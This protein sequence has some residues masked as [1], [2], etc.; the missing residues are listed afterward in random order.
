M[1]T[2]IELTAALVASHA[3][4]T[5]MTSEQLTQEIQNVYASLKALE[6]GTATVE[7]STPEQPKLTIKQAFKKD[8]VI[9]MVCG[10]GGFKTLKRHLNQLHD[11]KPGAYRKQFNIPSSQPLVAKS[12]SESR[13][14]SANER[15]LGDVLAKAR[16]TRAAGNKKVDASVTKTTKAEALAEKAKIPVPMKVSKA[17]VPTKIEKKPIAVKTVK[18]KK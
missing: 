14:V 7:S 8:E 11:L 2:L 5:Q 16:A 9:C 12:Y 15:G 1:P 13:R 6:S 4:N 3:S 18:T 17:P 10:K